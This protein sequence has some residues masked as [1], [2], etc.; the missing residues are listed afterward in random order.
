M[1]PENCPGLLVTN[2][3]LLKVIIEFCW[4]LL[5]LDD[6]KILVIVTWLAIDTFVASTMIILSEEENRSWVVN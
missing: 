6:T 2:M 5:S 3:K 4:M 1:D